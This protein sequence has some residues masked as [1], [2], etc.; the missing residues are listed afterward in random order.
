MNP[1]ELA[2]LGEFRL[3]LQATEGDERADILL[4]TV[5]SRWFKLCRS[6][7][8]RQ[9]APE[10]IGHYREFQSWL[11]AAN[12]G[13]EDAA[14]RQHWGSWIQASLELLEQLYMEQRSSDSS[15]NAS[16]AAYE[17]IAC[18]TALPSRAIRRVRQYITQE[19]SLTARTPHLPR[20]HTRIGLFLESASQAPAGAV[21]DLYVSRLNGTG[22]LFPHPNSV[23]LQFEA[24]F[25][26]SLKAAQKAVNDRCEDLR[27]DFQWELVLPSNVLSIKGHSAGAAFAF[28]MLSLA[29]QASCVEASS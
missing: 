11:G 1:G 17:T 23:F 4:D 12:A 24:E 15:G 27:W 7:Y 22:A 25:A 8:Q 2:S 6:S 13:D 5:S 20:V 28:A 19:R 21:A 14:Y 9:E 16:D 29:K 18:R 26:H 3:A 10:Q